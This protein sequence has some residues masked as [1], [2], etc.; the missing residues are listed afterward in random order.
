MHYSIIIYQYIIYY[1]DITVYII[2]TIYTILYTI[3]YIYVYQ[4]CVYQYQYLYYI[5]YNILC[6]CVWAASSPLIFTCRSIFLG[7]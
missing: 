1:T 4:Y 7:S 2:Y 5:L 3:L 6:V